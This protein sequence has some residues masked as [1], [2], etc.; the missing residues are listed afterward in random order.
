MVEH[1]LLGLNIEPNYQIIAD[2]KNN[3]DTMEVK[4]EMSDQML[5]GKVKNLEN[6]EYNIS[7]A[8]QSA[9]N[10]AAKIRLAE[11][12]SLPRSEGKAKRT[13][14]NRKI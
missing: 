8:L 1:V 7:S 11:P 12:K 5:S 6:T 13:I 3:L 14:D 2:R 4:A 10:I 9:L